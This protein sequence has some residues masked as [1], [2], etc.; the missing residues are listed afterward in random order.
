M[1]NRNSFRIGQIAKLMKVMRVRAGYYYCEA[2]WVVDPSTPAFR[3]WN[4]YLRCRS[5]LRFE[6]V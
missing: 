1:K 5:I 3:T 2:F 6:E 4:L